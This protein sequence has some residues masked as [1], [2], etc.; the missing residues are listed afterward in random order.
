MCTLS[1]SVHVH[2]DLSGGTSLIARRHWLSTS[3]M[4]TTGGVALQRGRRS[5]PN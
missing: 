5:S 4:R 1:M 3:A 2:V